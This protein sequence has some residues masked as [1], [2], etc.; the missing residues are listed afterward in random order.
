VGRHL[1]RREGNR[2]RQVIRRLGRS[3]PVPDG[4]PP[5][6][7]RAMASVADA[8]GPSRRKSGGCYRRGGSD[9][10]P[11]GSA[12]SRLGLGTVPWSPLLIS[13]GNRLA[14]SRVPLH[15]SP[16]WGTPGI[17]RSTDGADTRS[18]LERREFKSRLDK[19]EFPLLAHGPRR[20]CHLGGGWG[21]RA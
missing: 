2:Q 19:A 11:Q 5:S 7:Q 14:T 15:M 17:A 1:R 21:T 9:P 6:W 12:P 20:R 3:G 13:E 8:T 10:I 4:R 16:S 18:R